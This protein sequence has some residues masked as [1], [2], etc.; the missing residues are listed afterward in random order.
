MNTPLIAKRSR[1]A[2][3]TKAKIL[4]A[5]Q[6][7]F[8]VTGYTATG[9]RDVAALAGVS[10]TLIGRYFGSKAGLLEAALS[11]VTG[12]DEMFAVDRPHFGR[13]L[14]ELM[15]RDL[16]DHVS[17]GMTIF[18]ASDPEARVI[19]TRVLDRRVIRPLAEWLGGPDAHSRAVALTMLGAGFVLH[20]HQIPL[21]PTP[22]G[23]DEPIV[24]WLAKALQMIVDESAT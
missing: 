7:C 1:N 9:I 11:E 21:I 12:I 17:F 23:V 14:A 8:S 19:A 16:H 15:L 4:A 2:A 24:Q 6:Q 18:A 10:Y 13:H 3:V 20:A 5:A 22:A